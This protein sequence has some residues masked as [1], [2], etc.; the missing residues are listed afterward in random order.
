MF[1]ENVSY[2][3]EASLTNRSSENVSCSRMEASLTIRSLFS[4]SVSSGMEASLTNRSLFS[5]NVS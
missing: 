3:M 4:D 1:S 2:G 5:E